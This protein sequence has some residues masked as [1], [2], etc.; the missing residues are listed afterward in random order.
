MKRNV[1]LAMLA[2][3]MLITFL[4]ACKGGSDAAETDTEGASGTTAETEAAT[5]VP[6][7][8]YMEADVATDVTIDRADYMGLTLTIP[9]SYKI[10]DDDVQSYI[11]QKIRFQRRT[12][13]NGTAMV[14]DKELTLG[15][16][17]YIY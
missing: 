2:A 4:T 12:A 9:N 5:A 7:Y 16:D 1:L 3:A 17:A 8:D 10:E 14:K 6:R 13:V 15:D 11:L